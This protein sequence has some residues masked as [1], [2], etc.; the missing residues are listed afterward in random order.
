MSQEPVACPACGSRRLEVVF[1]DPKTAEFDE[2]ECQDCGANWE[3]CQL[4]GM[5]DA[6]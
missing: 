2:L 4:D 1:T 6:D 3:R 5:L